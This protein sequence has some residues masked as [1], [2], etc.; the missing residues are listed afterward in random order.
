MQ[1]S[2]A[3]SAWAL[4]LRRLGDE[5]CLDV[6]REIFA[7]PATKRSAHSG[8]TFRDA[9]LG[10]TVVNL[11]RL[12]SVGGR[13]DP[14]PHHQVRLLAL[15]SDDVEGIF[16]QPWE[17]G[18]TSLLSHF[19]RQLHRGAGARARSAAEA[20]VLLGCSPGWVRLGMSRARRIAFRAPPEGMPVLS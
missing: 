3:G 11:Y 4:A 6:C 13:T 17:F 12:N 9:V 7:C 20:F 14:S 1:W 8:P 2:W 15:V 10:D 19:G 5:T 18:A 16:R